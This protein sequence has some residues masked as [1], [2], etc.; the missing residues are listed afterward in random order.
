M[1]RREIIVVGCLMNSRENVKLKSKNILVKI[2]K[3]F[4]SES[5]IIMKE[6]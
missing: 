5:L 1:G 4:I 6:N 3:N 2:R